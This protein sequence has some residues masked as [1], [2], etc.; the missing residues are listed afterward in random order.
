[1]PPVRR[2][3]ME[4]RMTKVENLLKELPA[5][6]LEGPADA[7]LTLVTWGSTSGVVREAAEL[8]TRAGTKT[9]FLV[10]KYIAP[11]HSKEVSEILAKCKKKISVE[12]NFTSVMAQFI[13]MQTGVS[14]DGHITKYDGEPPE[15]L[16]VVEHARRILKGDDIDLDVTEEEAR[17]F[18]YHYLRTHNGEKLR[19]VK[20]IKEAKNG[21]GEPV[22]NVELVERFT[23][24]Q[25]GSMKIGVKTGSTYEFNKAAE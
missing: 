13:K 16:Y 21:H 2:K 17:E 9:N 4:K 25:G 8:L 14:M 24:K 12:V 5:P 6:V 15:P 7:E 3:I 23:G 11:F 20:V 19:P 1:A 22:W 18:V 10:I